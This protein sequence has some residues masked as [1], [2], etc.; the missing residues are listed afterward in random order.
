M[1]KIVQSTVS[2]DDYFMGAARHAATRSKDPSTKVGCVIVG[3]ERAQR[4]SGYN[5]PPPGVLDL[6]E[7]FERPAKYR[8]VLHA[9]ASALS[10]AARNGV[11][12]EGCTLYVTHFP[13]NECSKLIIAAGI[14]HL[15]YGAG[16][17]SMPDD[18]FEVSKTMLAEAGVT[19]QMIA[20]E[21]K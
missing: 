15:K 1:S 13:C 18:L 2:W 5:G 12:V 10:H 14:R 11:S 6:A 20:E 16:K 19:T 8:F 9:E 3:P 7:R 17:T 21:M 4:M